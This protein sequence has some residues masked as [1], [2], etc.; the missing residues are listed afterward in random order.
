MS[1]ALQGR[2]QA[3]DGLRPQCQVLGSLEPQCIER[4]LLEREAQVAADIDQ[5]FD[6]ARRQLGYGAIHGDDRH[7]TPGVQ[8]E[9]TR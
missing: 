4:G 2:R 5:R 7:F 8:A 6:G 1:L 3:L 9:L